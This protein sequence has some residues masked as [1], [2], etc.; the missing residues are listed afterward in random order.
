MSSQ[1]GSAAPPDRWRYTVA[2][3]TPSILA[4][5]VAV[6]PFSLRWRALAVS[7]SSTLRGP[8][9]LGAV[10][11]R[12]GPFEGGA[13][14]IALVKQV[15]FLNIWDPHEPVYNPRNSPGRRVRY[16]SVTG[17]SGFP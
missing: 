8:P 6:M 15:S 12:C 13:F 1:A 7:A 2:R 5:S 14:L 11:P 10:S 9:E 4:M 16:P 3:E 17:E